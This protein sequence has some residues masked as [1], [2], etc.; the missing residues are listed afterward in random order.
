MKKSIV[1]SDGQVKEMTYEEV[2]EGPFKAMIY[3]RANK[4]VSKFEKYSE[5]EDVMQDLRL[6]AWE[7][8]MEY[9]EVHAFSTYLFNKLRSVTGNEAQKITAKKRK[10]NGTISMNAPI[11]ESDEAKLEDVLSVDDN[12][13]GNMIAF[14][15]MELIKN[16]LSE[17][18]ME[19]YNCLMYPKLF[20]V[21]KL[22]EERNKSRQS[23]NQRVQKTKL[24]LQKLL[25]ANGFVNK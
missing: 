1:F 17:S 13:E 10:H 14:E 21:T 4:M 11:G 25:I 20:S 23:T 2:I 18:E 3:H 24:K 12:I 5:H 22:A 6:A 15:M 9:D 8:F 16:N 19:E 7:A